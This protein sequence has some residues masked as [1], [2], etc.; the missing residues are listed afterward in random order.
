MKDSI[1]EYVISEYRKFE[2]S[3]TLSKMIDFEK[4]N[5]ELINTL[6]NKL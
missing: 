1:E 3:I 4:N 2:T 6:M 5:K